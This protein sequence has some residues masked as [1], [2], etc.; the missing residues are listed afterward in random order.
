[1]C[2]G[3]DYNSSFTQVG[4]TVFSSPPLPFSKRME[5]GG[6]P[7]RKH[8]GCA[9]EKS[10]R[11]SEGRRNLPFAWSGG[12][13]W[14]GQGHTAGEWQGRDS[15][16]GP[17]IMSLLPFSLSVII[18]L[19]VLRFPATLPLMRLSQKLCLCGFY[20]SIS[21]WPE[22]ESQKRLNYVLIKSCWNSNSKLLQLISQTALWKRTVF[23]NKKESWEEWHFSGHFGNSFTEDSRI[24]SPIT[25][26]TFRSML[27]DLKQTWPHKDT[28]I[29]AL[30]IIL[31]NLWYYTKTHQV[32][33]SGR[34]VAM[35]NLKPCREFFMYC[36]IKNALG[37]FVLCMDL[38]ARPDLSHV[39]R[40][41]GFTNSLGCADQLNVDTFYDT[42]VQNH[43]HL[44]HRRSYKKSF[45][46]GDAF[47]PRTP[48]VTWQHSNFHLKAQ[49]FALARHTSSYFTRSGQTAFVHFWRCLPNT[50]VRITS[51]SAVVLSGKCGV[52]WTKQLSSAQLQPSHK[53]GSSGLPMN[54]GSQQKCFTCVS[55]FLT[56]NIKK[57]GIQ[58]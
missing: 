58:G 43:M 35:N 14:T 2:S 46:F 4:F 21:T 40:S 27:K 3:E 18:E 52:P 56:L 9:T 48:E 7:Y 37:S 22:I 50:Q 36:Y 28:G 57:T 10:L 42:I 30:G 47:K 20:L 34:L 53:C 51:F 19:S 41:L 11:A 6:K 44:C 39:L 38:W 13:W 54:L 25:P 32:A 5:V 31:E 17:L 8:L 29:I 12:D 49:V 45:K 16:S 24:S 33:V 15:N 23:P 26:S 55:H 1:M